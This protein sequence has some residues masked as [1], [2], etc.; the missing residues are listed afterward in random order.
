MN[1]HF[2]IFHYNFRKDFFTFCF[3][4]SA[5][6][7]LCPQVEGLDIYHT[8][9]WDVTVAGQEAGLLWCNFEVLLHSLHHHWMAV[10][11]LVHF[12]GVCLMLLISCRACY[13][14]G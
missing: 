4:T 11:D 1:F 6:I 13:A 12:P 2:F 10:I 9:S 14:G 3:R 7:I 8:C 5:Y